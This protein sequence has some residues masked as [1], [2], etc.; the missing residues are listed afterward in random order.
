M[1]NAK[2]SLE[3]TTDTL[4]EAVH[5]K[6]QCNFNLSALVHTLPS[7]NTLQELIQQIAE[8]SRKVD[9]LDKKLDRLDSKV[10]GRHR[11]TVLSYIS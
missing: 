5:N 4:D 9:Q 10:E 8:L 11:Q 1:P 6:K 3:Q 7:T 2:R